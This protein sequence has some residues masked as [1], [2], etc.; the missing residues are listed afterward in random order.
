MKTM[1][2]LNKHYLLLITVLLTGYFIQAAEISDEQQALLDSLPADQ[3]DGILS[4]I[5]RAQGL[6][7]EIEE[8]FEETESLVERPELE[9]LEE[10]EICE[11]CIYGY[12]FFQFSPTT[13]A[14]I[15]NSPVSSSYILGP[16][17]K[18]TIN[19]FGNEESET[20]TYVSREGFIILPLIGRVNLIGL[21]FEEATE[22]IEKQVSQKLIG[23]DVTISLSELRSISVF[24]IGEAYK[25]GK[26]TLSGLSSITNALFVSGGVNE[27]GSLRNIQLKRNNEIITTYD[28]YDFLINGSSETEANLQ[29]GDVLFIPFIEN[30]VRLGGAF[31]RPHIYEFKQGETIGDAIKFAG[32]FMSNVAPD[33]QIEIN[34]VDSNLFERRIRYISRNSTLN[35]SLINEDIITISS[36]SIL[37]PQIMT[38]TGEVVNPGQ[39]SIIDGDTVL[40]LINRAGGYTDNSFSEG[41]VYLRKDVAE[42]QKLGFLRSAD[43]LEDTL[44]SIISNMDAQIT[45]FSLAP[46]GRLIQRLREEEPVGR[47]VVDVD[48]LTLKTDPLKNFRV[49]GGDSLFIPKRP[50]TVSVVGEVLYAASQSYDPNLSARDY[51]DLSGGLK[52]VADQDRVFVIGPNGKS[53]LVKRSL[54]GARNS[55]LPGSTIVVPRDPRPL[56]GVA[57]TQIITPVLADL[58][59][60]AAAIAAISD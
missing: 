2:T 44:V 60:S 21:T 16:G 59:T 1:K 39:Y 31:K 51:I 6:Q 27:N 7:E 55:I 34:S 32:G 38:I 3:R 56:D 24:I 45:E 26:Y 15:Q 8:A 58:A 10:D 20:E 41:A 37:Q 52:D 54:F 42:Q 35:N 9:E 40:D 57:L 49:R 48:Y 28:F 50:N 47:F 25:P 30:R 4:K 18:L 5:K 29:D 46:I 23:I 43:E 11:D 17:D 12:D 22:Y 14:P 13:F 33:A 19:Y 53:A 36:K